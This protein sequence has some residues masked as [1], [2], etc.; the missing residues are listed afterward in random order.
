MKPDDAAAVERWDHMNRW[1]ESFLE[2]AWKISAFGVSEVRADMLSVNQSQYGWMAYADGYYFNVARSLPVISGHGGYDDMPGAYFAPGFFHE[3]GRARD[4]NKPVWY[5]PMWYKESSDQCRLQQYLSFMTDL[6]GMSKPPGMQVQHPD[7][8]SEAVGIVESNKLM[9]RLGT[10]F[11]TMRPTRP[12][13]AVLYSLSQDLGAEVHDMQDH[14]KVG[15]AAYEGG[16]HVRAKMLAAR[17]WRGKVIHIPLWPVVEEDVLDG[18]LAANHKAVLLAGVN[19]LDAKVGGG[20]WKPTIVGGGVVLVSDDCQVQIKGAQK[21]GI[22]TP[23]KLYHDIGTLWATDQ[24]KSQQLRRVEF[25]LKEVE[26]FAKALEA[27]LTAIGVKPALNA[28]SPAILTQQQA[29]GDIE[30]L[31]AVNATPKPDDET[32]HIQSAIVTLSVAADGR[33]IYDAVHGVVEEGFKAQGDRLSGKFHFGPGAMRV[34]ART[35]RPIGGVQVQT[36]VL[37]RDFTVADAPVRI[38]AAATL[39][40]DQHTILSGSAPL[41]VRLIDPLG[42]VRY[43]LY[44]ATDRG[45]L[46]IDL[47]LAA[48]DPAGQW[49]LEVRELLSGKEGAASFTYRPATQCAAAA[50]ATHRAVYF[51]NDREHIF[52]LFRTHQKDFTVIIGSGNYDAAAERVADVLKPWGVQCK[53]V[54]AAD[55][56]TR[57]VTADEAGEDV[58]RPGIWPGRSEEDQS[59]PGRI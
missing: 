48:N 50:G 47:P 33:P 59:R 18:S 26:P 25:W 32:V 1:K 28:D 30:Y 4:V 55:V 46:R 45:S 44:R 3:M 8:S 54:K 14:A 51:G 31:F 23:T 49:K 53:I 6:Q 27:K 13:V 16:D 5:M 15:Q 39:V 40:D 34:F 36:P 22:E 37:F 9:A 57:Q 41:E 10:I 52:K 7:N 38:E 17:I 11:T 24:K 56:K 21:L 35:A 29:Q 19:F 42:E 12:E 58:E 2:A 43:D 20:G